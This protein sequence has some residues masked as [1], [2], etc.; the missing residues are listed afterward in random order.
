MK[1]FLSLLAGAALILSAMP[2]GAVIVTVNR[3][4]GYY[5][6]ANDASSTP[7]NYGEFTV[8]PVV[9]TGYAPS[10]LV[11]GGF[12]TFCLE[13][14][15][16]V[17]AGA[18]YDATVNAQGIAIGGGDNVPSGTGDKISF[19]TAYLYDQFTRGILAGY[20][21]TPGAL[22][23]DSARILQLTIWSLEG[24]HLDSVEQAYLNANNTFLTAAT[25][26]F[27]ANVAADYNN[28]LVGVAVLHLTNLDG[29]P[30]QDLLVRVPD[31][32][33]SIMLLGMA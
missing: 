29:S 21:Y 4:A 33:A 27:G 14:N 30:A 1:Q 12:E 7:H 19:G 20:N 16:G 17:T 15:E 10:V 32:G 28:Q 25:A 8:S 24:E 26:L 5:A 11:N 18:Q 23:G 3:T 13:R 31:G 6:T 9:G 22:R 2:A